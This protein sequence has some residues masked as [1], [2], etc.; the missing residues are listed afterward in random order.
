MLRPLLFEQIHMDSRADLPVEDGE[1]GVERAGHAF[2]RRED[3]SAHLRQQ[4]RRAGTHGFGGGFDEREFLE[5]GGFVQDS[6]SC[7]AAAENS[8]R[9]EPWVN[10]PTA[11]APA[12]AKEH[13]GR[14]SVAPDG[15]GESSDAD[16]HGSR[17]GLP[18]S[19]PP[20]LELAATALRLGRRT[21]R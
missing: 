5:H 10:G 18:A 14:E 11:S 15:A 9:R 3:E 13:R 1:T 4:S 12:G 20:M 21:G 19:A 2:P 8:P 7:G 6:G 17:R 16:S